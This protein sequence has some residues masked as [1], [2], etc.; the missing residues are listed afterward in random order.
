M[1]CLFAAFFMLAHV[2]GRS[3]NPTEIQL[4]SQEK[5]PSIFEGFCELVVYYCS[6]LNTAAFPND[7]HLIAGKDTVCYNTGNHYYKTEMFE[8]GGEE[9]IVEGK[10][11]NRGKLSLK[12]ESQ[13][14][15]VLEVHLS[16]RTIPLPE[17]HYSYD[18]PVLYVHTDST[19]Q[20]HIRVRPYGK[21][22]FTYPSY[23]RGWSIQAN[24]D[25]SITHRG[26]S[27]QYLF[28]EGVSGS[29]KVPVDPTIGFLVQ[30]DSLVNFF[31]EKLTRLGFNSNEQ[32]DFITYWVPKMIKYPTCYVHLIINEKYDAIATHRILPKPDHLVRVFV[33]WAGMPEGFHPTLTPQEIP[34]S[35]LSGTSVLEWGGTEIPVTL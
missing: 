31:E 1:R 29:T 21:F 27:Y 34:E 4:L 35:K 20:M 12:L 18:K 28:W 17:I 3:N 24:T 8:A 5:D 13:H 32:A 22:K 6:P 11:W 33:F 30:K 25:G 2:A 7:L 19:Q 9:I 26:R 15:Y 16:S 14:R 23:N 10:W